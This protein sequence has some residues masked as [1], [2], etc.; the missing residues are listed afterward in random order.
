MSLLMG[1]MPNSTHDTGD[2]VGLSA[3]ARRA[4]TVENFRKVRCWDALKNRC[5]EY[6]IDPI[7]HFALRPDGLQFAAID[8]AGPPRD[9]MGEIPIH[10]LIFDVDKG[11]I[12]KKLP[13]SFFPYYL[14]YCPDGRRIVAANAMGQV[15][16]T[17]VDSGKLWKFNDGPKSAVRAVVVLPNSIRVASGAC[18]D[19]KIDVV[20]LKHVN[21]YQPLEIWDR[22]LD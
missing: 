4:V 17:D 13:S 19:R 16:V 21:V 20:T 3:E 1:T 6:I 5:F 10:I 18:F 7:R 9:I 22:K 14:C 2:Y 8:S 11:T 15:S 12:L